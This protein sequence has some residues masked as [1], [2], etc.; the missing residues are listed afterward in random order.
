VAAAVVVVVLLLPRRHL[1]HAHPAPHQQ[2]L[3]LHQQ[4]VLPHPQLLLLQLGT[5][6]C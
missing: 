3:L 2:P 4:P 5:S 6:N 1:Q